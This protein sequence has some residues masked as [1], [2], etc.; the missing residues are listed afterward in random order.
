M[1]RSL[2]LRACVLGLSFIAFFASVTPGS[3]LAQAPADPQRALTAQA[4]YEQATSEM[5]AGAYAAA[6][7]KLEEVT[8]LI[9][10]GLGAKL[11]L[12]QCYE[13]VGR[14]ASAWAQY[15]LV[16][17]LASQAGQ[18][19]RAQSSAEK[20]AALK[21][22]LAQLTVQVPSEV[23]AIPGLAITGDGVPVGEPQ[24]G[25]PLP[26][27]KGVHSLVA[28]AP[29]RRPWTETFTVPEDGASITIVIKPPPVAERA[30]APARRQEEGNSA[31]VSSGSAPS[32]LQ[33]PLAIGAIGVGAV[34]VVAGAILGGLAI[35]TFNESNADNHCGKDNHCDDTGLALRHKAVTLGDGST[36]AFIAGAAVLAGGV[37]LLATAPSQK[38]P[39]P[40][41]GATKRATARPRGG[42]EPRGPR[43]SLE[44]SPARLLVNVT[45]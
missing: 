41:T 15:A 42:A 14:L 7:P 43:A 19:A 6:C 39:Q 35:S 1:R 34:G 20:A 11:T 9:P 36:G 12:A 5:D 37:V 21:P 45:W 33:R 40:K 24:W 4:L 17:A 27:D 10:D 3:A 29:G 2:G 16:E 13:E 8:R 18:A 22:Q 38:S 26:V 31:P 23:R 32:S 25:M 30:P 44:L 28:T